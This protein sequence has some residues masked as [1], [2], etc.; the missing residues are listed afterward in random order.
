M[1]GIGDRQGGL[2]CCH[3]WD[4]KESDTTEQLNWTEYILLEK[5]MATHSSILA[6]KIPWTEEPTRLQSMGLPRVGQDWSIFVG[7]L[8]LGSMLMIIIVTNLAWEPV[9]SATLSLSQRYVAWNPFSL[10]NLVQSYL[11][12]ALGK[13]LIKLSVLRYSFLSIFSSQLKSV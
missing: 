6:W 10:A 1:P 5:E 3:S 8:S 13:G 4:R 9:F 7:M 2:A 11:W 12:H